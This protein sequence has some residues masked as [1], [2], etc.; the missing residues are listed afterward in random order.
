MTVEVR[1]TFKKLHAL[2]K[3][4]QMNVFGPRCLSDLHRVRT[5]MEKPGKVMEF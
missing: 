5:V 3:P 2:L 4:A 1:K